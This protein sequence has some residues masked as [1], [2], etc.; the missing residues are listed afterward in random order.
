[1]LGCLTANCQISFPV[2]PII[3]QDLLVFSKGLASCLVYHIVNSVEQIGI[4]RIRRRIRL[5][6]LKIRP[7]HTV[8]VESM[9]VYNDAAVF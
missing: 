7:R 2:L 5:D 8:Y 4:N 6:C 9:R 3:F 1:M